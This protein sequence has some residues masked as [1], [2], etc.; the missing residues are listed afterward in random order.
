M[1]RTITI[2]LSTAFALVMV[3]SLAACGNVNGKSGYSTSYSNNNPQTKSYSNN[4]PQT[5]YDRIE[6]FSEGLAWVEDNDYYGCID[7][8]GKMLFKYNKTSLSFPTKFENGHAFLYNSGIYGKVSVIDRNGDI[9]Y[10]FQNSEAFGF[11]LVVV[12]SYQSS[13]SSSE[14][15]YDIYGSDGKI[16]DSC[17][18]DE[19]SKQMHVFYCGD[20]VFEFSGYGFYC[21]KT[22]T[23][24]TDYN[25]SDGLIRFNTAGKALFESKL[26]SS[27]S[28]KLL[29]VFANSDGT[30]KQL[31]EEIELSGT[32]INKS[33][34]DDMVY[35]YS[36]NGRIL[37]PKILS[38]YNVST[39]TKSVLKDDAIIE[40]LNR[41]LI[42]SGNEDEYTLNCSS[43]KNG[44]IVSLIGDDT[45]EYVALLDSQ[46]NTII[47]P[48]VKIG[49]YHAF[50]NGN[51]LI[52][53]SVYD[54]NG[55]ELY[56]VEY[57]DVISDSESTIIVQ[58]ER[59]GNSDR[60]K[61]SPFYAI[62]QEGN[63]VFEEIDETSAE[64]K[65]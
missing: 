11:G 46:L 60:Y 5:N 38:S 30:F 7:E 61:G 37:S 4:N 13:F 47:E 20:G 28:Y 49:N 50:D 56:K 17:T 62:D 34:H 24:V 57:D 2:I 27:D 19:P 64:I 43:N 65:Q 52:N 45:I 29:N 51:F 39:E 32:R 16:V 8:T 25:D 22:S 9:Q 41:K 3:L 35:Y 14:Y 31:P 55:T 40:R 10:T 63:I 23:W 21:A 26:H 18:A 58:G 33:L 53:H 54:K 6:S 42:S 1:K 15:K 12:E 59:N 48:V 44:I 36:D